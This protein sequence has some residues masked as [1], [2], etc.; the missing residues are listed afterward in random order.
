VPV[1]KRIIAAQKDESTRYI[2]V[3]IKHKKASAI[4]EVENHNLWKTRPQMHD[5]AIRMAKPSKKQNN[6]H[7]K[8]RASIDVV[9]EK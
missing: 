6:N 3:L 2:I 7:F 9:C 8:L 5:T 1:L 4:S